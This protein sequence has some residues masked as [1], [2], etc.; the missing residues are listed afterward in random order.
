MMCEGWGIEMSSRYYE[1][2]IKTVIDNSLGKTWEEA[3]KEWEIIDCEE[4]EGCSSQCVCGKENIKYLYLIHNKLTD[5]QLFPIG[6][7]CINKFER[8]DLNEEIKNKEGLFKLMHAILNKEKI[9]MDARYFSRKILYAL[10]YAD[11]FTDNQYND[12]NGYNDFLFLLEMFNKRDKSSIT[13]AQKR[14]INALIA[15]SIKPYL[16]RTLKVRK[17]QYSDKFR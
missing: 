5:K 16:I 15:Y 4:D 11:A 7:T 17:K 1:N 9:E 6:S 14:K 3:V 12:F 10:Y 13:Y 8:D 2:L